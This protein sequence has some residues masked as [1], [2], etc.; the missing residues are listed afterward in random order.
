[1]IHLRTLSVLFSSLFLAQSSWAAEQNLSQPLP[2]PVIAQPKAAP[3]PQTVAPQPQAQPV[4]QQQA[5]QPVAPQTTVQATTQQVA[6]TL[7]KHPLVIPTQIAVQVAQ[8]P[9]PLIALNRAFLVYELYLTNY[10]RKPLQLESIQVIAPSETRTTQF[11][12]NPQQL[13]SMIQTLGVNQTPN[14]A[15]VLQPGATKLIFVWLPF[16]QPTFLPNTLA[17]RIRVHEVGQ[18]QIRELTT[19]PVA[20]KDRQPVIVAGPLRGDRWAAG[21]GPSNDSYHRR[22]HL[23]IDGHGYLAQRYAID[24]VKIDNNGNTY[25]DNKA[26][27]K[28]YYAYGQDVLAVADGRIVEVK[29]GIPENIPQSGKTAVPI[30]LN[31]VGGNYIVMDIGY[32]RYAFYAHLI[33][34]SLKIKLGDIVRKGQVMGKLGNSGNSSEP[35]LHFHIVDTPSFLGAN[36]VPYAFDQVA[37]YSSQSTQQNGEVKYKVLNNQPVSLINQLVLENAVLKFPLLP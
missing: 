18:Q 26:D 28:N 9:A 10:E 35:H 8:L 2:Q 20:I 7:Q 24:F 27:N 15:L 34:G 12:F 6:A 23:V 32:G 17:H 25:H 22:A 29:D 3:V 16:E 36:G 5:Q 21:G 31:T 13:I 4:Q 14:D 1:M 33:P 37:I 30:D 19:K 11:T